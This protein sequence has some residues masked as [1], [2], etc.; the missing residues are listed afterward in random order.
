MRWPI[1]LALGFYFRRIERFH[2]GRVP[3]TGPVLIVANHPCSLTD[4]FVVG[5]AV[6]RPVSFM[7][8][9]E[10]FR[11][12][13]FKWLLSRCGVIPVNR[14][15]DDPRGMKSVLETFERCYAVM[16]RGGAV[17]LF[18][19]GITHD[20]PQLKEVKSGAARMAL[21]LEH[22]HAGK[23]GLTI[24]P[25]GL[26]FSAKEHYRSDVLVNFGEPIRAADF[27]AGYAERRKECINRLTGEIESRIKSLIVHLPHLEQARVVAAVKRLYLDRLRVGDRVVGEPL[28]P[29]ADELALTRRIVQAVDEVNRI[30]PAR[31][32]AFLV[33]L[34]HYQSMM[35]RLHL[36]DEVVKSGAEPGGL[37]WSSLGLSVVALLGLPLASYG[38]LHRLI[39]FAIV[40]GSVSRFAA[41]HKHKAQVPTA[42]LI[43]GVVAFGGFYG[44][45]IGLCH[46]IWGWPVSFWYALSLPVASLAAHYYA[47]EVRRLCCAL[48][49]LWILCRAP[50]AV[51]Q[52]VE[53]RGALVAEIESVHQERRGS[54]PEP[55]AS[56]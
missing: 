48:R 11:F 54:L 25:V 6:A 33:R 8:T 35:E 26:N 45:C 2:A 34:D 39:P 55:E 38:W 10:L 23:L 17:A 5:H 24:V 52:L 42:A 13:P 40:R 7:A 56:S 12:A 44:G 49:T 47:R 41:P 37:A 43:A 15:K 53:V 21:E 29:Q 28:S 32:E 31:A 22:R 46:W 30:Q 3:A 16:E 9:V 18:P 14:L 36:P 20:D 51:R 19:E 27:R 50:F 1:G 4:S